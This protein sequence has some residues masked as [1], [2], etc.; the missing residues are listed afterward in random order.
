M[1]KSRLAQ[2][3]KEG[4]SNH[5]ISGTPARGATKRGPKPAALSLYPVKPEDVTVILL[6]AK[7]QS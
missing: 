6:R 5:K 1:K 4:N 7:R 3:V 2:N